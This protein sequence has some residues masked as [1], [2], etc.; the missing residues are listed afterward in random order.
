MDVTQTYTNQKMT[1]QTIH[2]GT[3]RVEILAN[4]DT[5]LGLGA[6]WIGET[7]VRSGRLPLRPETQTFTGLELDR[8]RLHGI[9]SHD[10]A[11]HVCLQADFRPLPVKLMRDHSLDPIHDTGDWTSNGA[12][13]GGKLSLVIKPASDFFGDTAFTGFSYYYEYDSPNVPL[14]YLMDKAS[15]ELDGDIVGATVVS[16][17]SCS[18][19]FVT[20]VPE[21]AWTTEGILWFLAEDGCQNPVMTH[22]LPRWA[23]HQAFD[24]QYKG[25][26]TLM[27]VFEHV[28]LIRSILMREAGK[29]ELKT[30]DK[31]LFDQTLQHRTPAKSILLSTIPKTETDQKNLWTWVFDAIGER[32]RA[33]FG[34]REEPLLPCIQLNMWRGFVIDDYRK[35]LLPAAASVGVRTVY[36]D[37]LNKS[38]STEDS[39]HRD[40][41]WNM[42]A[43]HE[44]EIAPRLGG[45]AMLKTFLDDC[46]ASGIRAFAWTNNA[47]ALSSPINASERDEWGW[48]VKLDDTRVKSG[49]SYT[50]V[51]SMLNFKKD[52]PRR[53]W[54]DSLKKIK[55]ETGLDA[56][57]F[58]SFY[59]MGFMPVD[60]SD[61][62]P[63]TQ[64][65]EL[66]EAFKELQDAG[67]DFMIESFGP[68][69][70]PRHG[71]PVSYNIETI[72]ACYKIGLGTGYTTVP[73]GQE[74]TLQ[75][76]DDAGR[77][78]YILAHMTD[79]MIPLFVDGQRID[80]LWTAAHCQALADYHACRPDMHRRFLQEDAQAVLWH[81][82][83]ATRATVWSFTAREAVL[84][85]AVRNVT[86][87]QNLPPAPVY[88][89]DR[90][91]TYT[92]SNCILPTFI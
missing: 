46:R 58:D 70:Q 56:Y 78:F 6:I 21:T 72:F 91:H 29:P 82:A 88:H 41:H 19:P 7:Q 61:Q 53:Y 2:I 67:I 73:S 32:A 5:F 12:K 84:P 64:W 37:N 10:T 76:S 20:F 79:P 80:A 9:E 60:F 18:N 38:A 36:I 15:W 59:N 28:D 65:R 69:G 51:I 44:Y 25:D 27:G 22:N 49:A 74:V 77:L 3:C 8:L 26:K 45:P 50:N 43:G 85:G 55:A 1:T 66:L 30:F 52:A 87:G 86:T 71:C 57:L 75:H 4:E 54:I 48:F 39:P 40:F 13:L 16:Q 63:S 31:Y 35:D 47:Q 34:L 42:C 83:D 68:F 89:L 33:E 14:F 17:S 90:S 81:D 11:A 24:F 23:S 92:I 62:K